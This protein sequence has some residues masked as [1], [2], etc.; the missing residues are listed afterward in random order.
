[1]FSNILSRDEYDRDYRC[2]A[3]ESVFLFFSNLSTINW[4]LQKSQSDN[5]INKFEKHYIF[6]SV[7]TFPESTCVSWSVGIASE[8]TARD[9]RLQS[10]NTSFVLA[11][12]GDTVRMDH[13]LQSDKI[14]KN[15]KIRFNSL[16]TRIRRSNP[17]LLANTA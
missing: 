11:N 6:L 9:S 16:L 12:K 14:K 5:P 2:V 1:M 8:K 10:P 15:K 17:P 3:T 4:Y 13:S 7:L